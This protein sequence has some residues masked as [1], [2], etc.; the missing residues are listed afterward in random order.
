MASAMKYL[1]QRNNIAEI[2][3]DFWKVF[4]ILKAKAEKIQVHTIY[5]SGVAYI[6]GV[7][8]A[9]QDEIFRRPK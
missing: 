6:Q 3:S 4:R 1:L 9:T 2:K 8:E 7:D 5:I